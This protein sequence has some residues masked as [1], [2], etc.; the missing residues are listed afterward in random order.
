MSVMPR[1]NPP[2]SRP[3]AA[4]LLALG[5]TLLALAL[6]LHALGD[7]SV[8]FY[9][10]LTTLMRSLAPSC[11]EVVRTVAKQYPPYIDF[12]PP[13]YYLVVHAFLALGHTDFLARLPAALSG[14]ASIPLL[15]L[16]GRRLG[17]GTVGLFAAAGLAVNLHH[18]E[19]SQQVRLYAFFGLVS[20]AAVWALLRALA[21]RGGRGAGTVQAWGLFALFATLGL[22]TSYLSAATLLVAAGLTGLA[23][24]WPS[25]I[26]PD[27]RPDTEPVPRQRRVL[28]FALAMAASLAAFA[29]WWLATSG[30]RGYLLV[31][32]APNRP[33]LTD[34]L[35]AMLGPFSSHYASF[36][37]RPELPWLLGAPALL[38]LVVGLC[39]SGRRRGTVAVLVWLVA[40]FAPVWLRANA[41]HH[42]QARYLLPCLPPLLVLAG[43]AAAAVSDLAG[44][45]RPVRLGQALR[46]GLPVLL[47]LA[48]AWPSVDVYPFF[49]RRDDSRLKTLAGFLGD[50]AG[51]GVALELWGESPPWSRPYFE[52]FKNWYLPGVFLP[53]L[54]EGDRTFRECLTLVPDAPEVAPPPREAV[55][56][57]R[58][59]RVAVYRLPLVSAAPI[60]VTPDG[61][62]DFAFEA[63]FRLPGAFSQAYASRN[64]RL[65]G[66]ALAPAD[67]SRP[68]EITYALAP[69]PGQTVE[70]TG[71][72]TLA[73]MVAGYP[74]QP[75]S[76]RVTVLTGSD[77]KNLTPYDPAHPPEPGA[78]LFV[79]L[80]LDPGPERETVRVIHLGISARVAGVPD[81]GATAEAAFKRRLAANTLV[82]PYEPATLYPGRRPLAVIE[83]G[84]PSGQPSGQLAGQPPVLTIGQ[85]A[86]VDPAL[87]PN[88][89]RIASD[90]PLTLVNPGEN[91]WP[92]TTWAVAGP[93]N[94]PHLALG[95]ARFQIPLAGK[96][97]LTARL[98]ARGEGTAVLAPLFTDDGY[99]PSFA[100]AID[101][102]IKL[103]G[104]PVLSCP[105][106]KPC[107][108]TYACV[109][110]YPAKRLA[111]AWFPRV[112]ADTAGKNFVQAS[113]SLDGAPFRPLDRFVGT[114]SGR[115]EGLGV[116]RRAAVDLDG[117]TGR[118]A[119]RFELASDAAQLW[120]AP[121][122]P[123]AV[124]V[125]LDTR[126]LPAL[127]LVPGR[128]LLAA[129]CPPPAGMVVSPD[130]TSPF[131]GD[132][133]GK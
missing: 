49:Y 128:A 94:G 48:L 110:G 22:Y 101:R 102:A 108:V 81:P 73:A 57:A 60:L 59:A 114:G 43:F 61:G 28:G 46:L 34:A 92:L 75:A 6:R 69:L 93:P 100:D 51:P 44:R 42:F 58:L 103:A 106:G 35:A 120:S 62:G 21:Q 52:A 99:D 109:T 32:A 2:K 97:G 91:P 95:E 115:W 31:A 83:D 41:T 67:R 68:G 17:G 85:T 123:M 74:G 27:T 133:C 104:Q 45:L 96:T 29:P 20:L 26:R 111:L 76:G 90:R 39:S 55:L 117:F 40:A 121:E 107:S 37:G 126:S 112:F 38:G 131:C 113:Y 87:A 19:A 54:P 56:L 116:G 53:A 64:V 84:E 79:R 72:P 36:V 63:D 119:V 127:S 80:V 66:G 124:T 132:N 9:D 8:S 5:L 129:D 10:E 82:V 122:T 130:G 98:T 14:A 77:P 50:R 13:L 25:T 65:D 3:D 89:G 33:P 1:E 23:V 18:I 71:A 4:D 118:I 24:L 105:D 12:Q 47:G 86:Y 11:G 15:Y 125:T 16:V 30:M 70:L 88:F 7:P 78:T